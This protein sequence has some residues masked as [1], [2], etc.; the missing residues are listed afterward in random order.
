MTKRPE[1]R[2]VYRHFKGNSYEVLAVAEHSETGEE[3]VIYK[4]LYGEGKIYARPLDAFMGKTDREKY[5]EAGQEYRFEKI[6]APEAQKETGQEAENVNIDPMVMEFL[7]ADTYEERLNIL[8]ALKH[9]I[10]DDMVTTMAIACDVEI[11]EGETLK[12]FD[13]LKAC[14]ITLEKYE[15]NRLR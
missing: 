12:R 4:A 6:T 7:E 10:T 9:R 1:P 3:L 11:G 15:C 14:L 2:E 13:E 5:P 8:A